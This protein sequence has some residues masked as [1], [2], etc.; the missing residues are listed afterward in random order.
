MFQII[1]VIYE[2]G[3]F[4]PLMKLKI[5]ARKK[6]LIQIGEKMSDLEDRMDEK[7]KWLARDIRLASR[8]YKAGNSKT[9]KSLRARK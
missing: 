8:E 7:D 2:H 9:L 4:R 1:P 5:R 3:V 6:L